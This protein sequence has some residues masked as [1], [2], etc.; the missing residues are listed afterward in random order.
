MGR[1][2]TKGFPQGSCRGPGYWKVLY[3]SMLTLELTR[4]SIAIAFTDNLLILTRGE[5]VVE[6][7]N[8]MNL[9]MRKIQEWAQNN[10]LKFNENKSKVMLM[11]RRK[12]KEKGY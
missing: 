4:H 8:Y 2:V 6:A 11:T 5:T 3:N 10:K 12:R 7:E 9:E 1:R